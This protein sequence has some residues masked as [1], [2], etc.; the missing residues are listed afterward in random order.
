MFVMIRIGIFLKPA[1]N[2]YIPYTKL[3]KN[4]ITVFQKGLFRVGLRN[5]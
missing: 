1:I 5:P 4:T 3:T 2:L